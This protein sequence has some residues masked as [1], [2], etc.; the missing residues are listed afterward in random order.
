[1]NPLQAI[2]NKNSGSCVLTEQ[3]GG[4][5]QLLEVYD[6]REAAHLLGGARGPQLVAG[7]TVVATHR[8]E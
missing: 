8:L 7:S 4:L 1:M 2:V 6:I 5:F 3:Q